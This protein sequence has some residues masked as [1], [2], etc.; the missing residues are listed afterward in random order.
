VAALRQTPRQRQ[1]FGLEGIFPPAIL[2][3]TA[4]IDALHFRRVGDFGEGRGGLV[5]DT[6]AGGLRRI[7]A[8]AR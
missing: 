7:D 2:G 1:D 8:G 6:E 3:R 5:G 4:A